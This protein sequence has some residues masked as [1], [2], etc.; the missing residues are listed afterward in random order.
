MN[1]ILDAFQ[2]IKFLC[3][4][5]QLHFF[6]WHGFFMT[7][8]EQF[9]LWILKN[10]KT[11]N[12]LL[13]KLSETFINILSLIC[14]SPLYNAENSLQF[15]ITEWFCTLC[16]TNKSFSCVLPSIF[17]HHPW[18]SHIH[19]CSY[20]SHILSS[21]YTYSNSELHT[22]LLLWFS[23]CLELSPLPAS[24]Q[25]FGQNTFPFKIYLVLHLLGDLTPNPPHVITPDPP[26]GAETERRC[27]LRSQFRSKAQ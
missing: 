8:Y 12:T 18:C 9:Q 11:I 6:C 14:N 27:N 22:L 10:G 7:T 2:F 5:L 24:R 1:H 17:P 23:R 4:L 15:M 19:S 26:Q 16:H 13:I 20:S 3:H 21:L 25:R